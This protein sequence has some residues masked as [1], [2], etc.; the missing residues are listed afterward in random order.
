MPN[1][2]A[3]AV[4]SRPISE[5]FAYLTDVSAW[6]NWMSV[7]SVHQLE[8]GAPRIGTQAEG[9]MREGHRTDRFSFEI[10]TLEPGRL[11]GFRTLS[12]PIDW[13]GS[14]EVRALDAARTEVTSQGNMRLRGLRRLLEPF[15]AG[16]VRK[17]EAAELVRLRETL[18][19]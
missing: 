11:I 19:K 9:L 4:I 5:V 16:E 8:E 7:E 15:M 17:S 1:Y 6:S 12:G 13:S 10:T 2:R 3:S 18:E 14:W